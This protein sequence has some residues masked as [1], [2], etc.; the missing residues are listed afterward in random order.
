MVIA[1]G[2][3]LCDEGEKAVVERADQH[4]R[5]L[6]VVGV[7]RAEPSGPPVE[8]GKRDGPEPVRTGDAVRSQ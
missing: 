7:M 6:D 1:M 5:A 4:P 3:G 2:Q 8:S